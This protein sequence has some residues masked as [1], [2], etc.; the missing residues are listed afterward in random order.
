MPTDTEIDRIARYLIELYHG[1]AASRAGHR[2]N[3]LVRE[4]PAT[5]TAWRRIEHTI[6]LIQEEPG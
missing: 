4:N 5:A 2:A 3:Y 1:D 6:R